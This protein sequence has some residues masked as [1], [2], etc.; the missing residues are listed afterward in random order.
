MKG[1]IAMIFYALLVSSIGI[2]IKL[3]GSNMSIW[4]VS[5][6]RVLFGFLFLLIVMPLFYWKDITNFKAIDMKGCVFIGFIMA[7]NFSVFHLALSMAPIQNVYLLSSI[8]VIFT[9]IF[10]FFFLKE[11]ITSNEIY[12]GLIAL[13]GMYIINPLKGDYVLGNIVAV[14]S[15]V[16]FAIVIV[17][18]RYEEKHHSLATIFWA[19]LFCTLFMLPFPFIFGVSGFSASFIWLFLLGVV[20]TGAA[21]LVFTYSLGKLEAEFASVMMIVSV[22][23]LAIVLGIIFIKEPIQ[24]NV[25]VGGGFLILAGIFLKTHHIKQ[26][27][28]RYKE[29]VTF[30]RRMAAK[31]VAEFSSKK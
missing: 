22:P 24:P 10:A 8:F 30:R 9:G 23:V 17:Y 26:F 15:A 3:V 25:I 28:I 18:L 5:F 21:Y 6:F 11:K 29:W 7:V 12:A 1:Y 13:F 20:C 27:T 14:C 16:F 19:M 2:F 31:A 4:S